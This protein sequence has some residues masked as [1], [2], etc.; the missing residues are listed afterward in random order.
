MAEPNDSQIR[1]T[2]VTLPPR[3]RPAGD[4]E[5]TPAIHTAMP[6][7]VLSPGIQV[8]LYGDHHD[9]LS[10]I[11]PR[12]APATVQSFSSPM[13]HHK[14]TP[15]AHREI[16]ETLNARSEYTNEDAE[17]R[18]HH[19]L[20]Q[21]V[22]KDEIG[23][24]SY[25]AVYLANDQ[26]GTEYAVKAFSKTRLRK[27]AQSDVLRRGP[28]QVGRFHRAGF[29]A[30]DAP[31]AGFTAQQA[32]EAKDALFLIR[33]EIAIMKKLNHP[34]LV[35]LIEVLDD[36]DDDTLYMV[37]EMC[38]KGVVMKVGLSEAAT[39]YE[40]EQCRH[41]FR[42]LILGIEYLHSQGVV[43]RDIKPE[44][45]LLTED[46]VLKIVDFGVSEMFEKPGQMRTAKSAGSPAFLPP[47]LCMAK[48]G[49]ISGKAADIWSMGVSLYCLRYGRIPFNRDGVLEMYEAIKTETPKLP[50]DENPDFVD[51]MGKMLEKDPEKRIEMADLREHPWV[52]KQGTDPLLSTEENCCDPLT[53]PNSLELNHAFTRKM[54][55]LICVMKA[56]HKFKSLLAP[57]QVRKPQNTLHPNSIALT[58]PSSPPGEKARPEPAISN[59]DLAAQLLRQRREF[60]AKGG[61]ASFDLLLG[62]PLTA[63]P[64]LISTGFTSATATATTATGTSTAPPQLPSAN[65]DNS[66]IQAN[67]QHPATGAPAH[68][69]PHLGIGTG[70]IDDFPSPNGAPHPSSANDNNTTNNNNTTTNSSEDAAT[71]V[72]SD[73]PTVV[74]FNVYDRAFEAEVERIKRSTSRRG[75][76]GR[77][78]PQRGAAS[79]VP[80]PGRGP[81]Q[82]RD[83]DSQ[84]DGAGD[85]GPEETEEEVGAGVIYQ[86]KFSERGRGSRYGGGGGST[87]NVGRPWGLGLGGSLGGGFGGREGVGRGPGPRKGLGMGLA[88]LVAKAVAAN[89][90]GNKQGSGSG[91]IAEGVK[92]DG[93]VDMEIQ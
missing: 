81:G 6:A 15:S 56:I 67:E 37:L 19:H 42:D 36:P 88:E 48:H 34:N 10:P 25:G 28:R 55:H 35:Q 71:Y 16:K 60:H 58:P 85:A 27:R 52:T 70:G 49:D 57:R 65:H 84:C 8:E 31:V 12:S 53:S 17:G 9:R 4:G 83:H 14:R 91:N 20:N 46:D 24:G 18:S 90:E 2:T 32:K 76:G 69:P 68:P 41:W 64:S 93:D 72:V 51:L 79:S 5:T 33:A 13:R 38:K 74:D 11:H 3:P 89:A 61:K 30:P 63:S 87:G 86:T 21:Y 47:E 50:P 80:V 1:E 22:I 54:S 7:G 78:F 44:N 40:E 92:N 43:H 23:R 29:G 59:A 73:S 26:F 82:G 77:G 75:R 66:Q 39:P 45:L 62:Q